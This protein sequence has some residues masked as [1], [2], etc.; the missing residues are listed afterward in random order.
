MSLRWKPSREGYTETHCG[1]FSLRP[2]FWGRV[3]ATEYEV[4]DTATGDKF[5]EPTQAQAKAR[6][7]RISDSANTETSRGA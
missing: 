5:R 4:K 1:R 3:S 6:A 7:E 2:I